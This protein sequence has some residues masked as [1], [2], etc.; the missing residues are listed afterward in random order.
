MENLYTSSVAIPNNLRLDTEIKMISWVIGSRG[1]LGS[2]VSEESKKSSQTWQ[3]TKKIIWDSNGS[4]DA[5]YQQKVSIEDAVNEFANT[6]GSDT[7]EIYWCAGIGVVGSDNELLDRE[8]AAINTLITCILRSGVTAGKNGKLF[9]ASSAGGVY[10]G[11]ANP[12]FTEETSPHS[13]SSYGAQKLRIE[14]LLLDFGQSNNFRV[15]I[16]RVA[17]IYGA[18]QNIRKNQG[19]VTALIKSTILNTTVSMY[20]P[21]NTIRNYIHASDA[22]IKI[23]N[24]MRNSNQNNELRNICSDENWSLGSLLRI[25]KEVAKKRIHLAQ[26]IRKE[27]LLQPLDLRIKTLHQTNDP[28]VQ[29]VS[30][31]VGIFMVREHLLKIHQNGN[32]QINCERDES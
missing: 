4:L 23:V 14:K 24:F 30:L 25:T 6:I 8:V 15:C 29:E 5:A 28:F 26:S 3:P 7:W 22:A 13:I 17:N 21:L 16:G 12:P 10:A 1:L 11:S 20:V 2:A 19:I 27:S 32:L 9:F 31:P 18:N